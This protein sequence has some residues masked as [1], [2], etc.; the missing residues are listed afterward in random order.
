MQRHSEQTAFIELKKIIKTYKTP[1]KK[2]KEIINISYLAI[3]KGERYCIQGAS[4]SGKTTLLNIIAGILLPDSGQV[5]INSVEITGLT[6]SLRDQ[7]RANRIGYVFQSINL[8]Q[9]YS[10][11]ENIILAGQFGKK[12]KKN[13]YD[14]ACYL[15][16]EVGLADKYHYKP[17]QLSFGQQQRV[18]I[19]RALINKPDIILADEPTGSL[20]QETSLEIQHLID[21]IVSSNNITLLV[22]THDEQYISLFQHKYLFKE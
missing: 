16:D 21:K 11:L 15:L 3:N 8:L 17:S 10:A 6:E 9:G 5:T 13:K 7:F 14:F 2:E 18:A 1:D 4:G 12:D 19:A 20:D 22:A